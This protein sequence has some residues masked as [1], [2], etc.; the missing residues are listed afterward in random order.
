MTIALGKSK[1]K[2]GWFDLVDDWLRQQNL[3]VAEDLGSVSMSEVMRVLVPGG[4]SY[5]R[6]DGR[7]TKTA[8]ARTRHR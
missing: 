5:V 6:Q 8:K 7:W 1:R 4:V 2:R 3:V